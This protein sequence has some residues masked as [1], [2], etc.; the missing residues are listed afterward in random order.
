[1]GKCVKLKQVSFRII[2]FTLLSITSM[3]LCPS[4]EANGCSANQKT[5]SHFMQPER[6]LQYSKKFATGDYPEPDESSS[7]PPIP[8]DPFSTIL[9]STPSYSKVPSFLHTLP[10]K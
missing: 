6:S 1:M 7:H 5:S 2:I 4:S 8:Y 3:G 9:Q 10:S